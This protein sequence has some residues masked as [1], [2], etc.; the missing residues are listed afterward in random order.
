[1][2]RNLTKLVEAA[3]ETLFEGLALLQSVDDGSYAA[4]PTALGT[5]SA[6]S[7]MRHCLEF[8]DCLLAGVDDLAVDY[9]ARRRDD[10]IARDRLLGMLRI[11]E[12][13]DRL[14]TLEG[15]D[16]D[17]RIFVRGED[18]ETGCWTP[19][20]IGREL[21]FLRSHTVH[22]YALMAIILRSQ[23]LEVPTA[24]GVAPSTLRYQAEATACAR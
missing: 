21:E 16:A 6:G 22:H 10:A 3:R 12:V 14:R 2:K 11:G 8:F 5:D 1:M 7:H 20:T 19:S 23:A 13:V 18:D 15:F 4:R 9:T 17:S 24:F